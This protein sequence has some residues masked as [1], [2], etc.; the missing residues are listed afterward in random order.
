MCVSADLHSGCRGAGVKTCFQGRC[1]SEGCFLL[2]LPSPLLGKPA[3]CSSSI[4]GSAAGTKEMRIQ[5]Q[6]QPGAAPGAAPGASGTRRGTPGPECPPGAG[7]GAG[8]AVSAA[9]SEGSPAQQGQENP[10]G[11]PGVLGLMAKTLIDFNRP[12]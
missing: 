3:R 8:Q 5:P 11:I 10:Q 1:S 4:A 6:T 12:C 2:L 7:T 9:R